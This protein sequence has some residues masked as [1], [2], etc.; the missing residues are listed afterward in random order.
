MHVYIYL[1]TYLFMYLFYFFLIY[2]CMY[3][4]SMKNIEAL[5]SSLRLRL[6]SIGNGNGNGNGGMDYDNIDIIDQIDTSTLASFLNTSEVDRYLTIISKLKLN[7]QVALHKLLS[8]VHLIDGNTLQHHCRIVDV[9]RIMKKSKV[10]PNE[11]IEK[12]YSLI[13]KLKRQVKEDNSNKTMRNFKVCTKH[14]SSRQLLYTHMHTYTHTYI[15]ACMQF[16]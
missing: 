15:H 1:S 6:D 11:L 4:G 10:L 8:C 12:I 9:L 16:I 7:I 14:C 2:L 3:I 5:V 13:S